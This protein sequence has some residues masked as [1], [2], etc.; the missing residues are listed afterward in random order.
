MRTG[1]NRGECAQTFTRAH[2]DRWLLII[3]AARVR[4]AT[5]FEMILRTP[6]IFI[7][8]VAFAHIAREYEDFLG[9]MK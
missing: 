3:Q 4:M 9:R 1:C 7:A 8:D 6:A 5:Q 2:N